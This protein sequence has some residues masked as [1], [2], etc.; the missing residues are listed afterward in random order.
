MPS[1]IG[2]FLFQKPNY[3]EVAIMNKAETLYRLQTIDLE[4]DEMGRRLKEVRAILGGNE[5]LQ[6][7]QQALQDEEKKLSRQRARLRDQELEMRSLTSKIASVEDQLYGG[8]VKNSKE[9]ASLQKEVQYLKRKKSE[10]EDQVLESMVEVEESEAGVTEQRERLARLEEE[11]QET[12]ARLSDEQNEL[13]NRLSQL[14]TKRAKLQRTI[15]AGDLA[16]YEDLRRRRGGRAVALLEGELCLGC[17]VTIP[18]TKAQQARQGEV[19]TL[20]TSCERI[21][22][23]ER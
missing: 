4:I 2:L 18:T 22:Y 10:F 12:Q 11:W 21:L 15:E 5:E 8:R 16:L 7:V 3:R 13:I 6:Q 1:G 23:V 14:K 19:L 20:C 9:L 17:R